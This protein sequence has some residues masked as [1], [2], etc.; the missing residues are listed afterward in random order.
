MSAS[1]TW[2]PGWLQKQL[3]QARREHDGSVA[4]YVAAS[5][6]HPTVRQALSDLCQA[7]AEHEPQRLAWWAEFMRP[8]L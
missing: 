3:K 6:E 7:V 2:K 5:S 1:D 4:V 8:R